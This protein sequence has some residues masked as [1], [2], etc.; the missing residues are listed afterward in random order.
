MSWK[1]LFTILPMRNVIEELKGNHKTY[2]QVGFKRLAIL[3][4]VVAFV[5]AYL[6]IYQTQL[7]PS[8]V[9]ALF[10]IPWMSA[11]VAGATYLFI[12]AVYWV[13]DGFRKED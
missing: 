4:T 8:A 12:R 9:D 10:W 5:I 13:I 2:D 7:A 6:Y 11:L 3:I 1:N